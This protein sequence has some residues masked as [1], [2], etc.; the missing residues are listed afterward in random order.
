MFSQTIN[1]FIKEVT[2][3]AEKNSKKVKMSGTEKT[4]TH[5]LTP[6][7]KVQLEIPAVA[8]VITGTGVAKVVIIADENLHPYIDVSV[9][10]GSLVLAK[11]EDVN[12]SKSQV[13]IMI[14]APGQL[15]HTG[16]FGSGEIKFVLENV[17]QVTGRVMGSGC[18]S[19]EGAVKNFIGSVNG[20]GSLNTVKLKADY[21]RIEI[22]GSGTV[23][24]SPVIELD[25][26]ILG[27]GKVSYNGNPKVKANTT[28]S[29]EVV[30]SNQKFN[31]N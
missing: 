29:G 11:T 22:V 9:T 4:E 15:E 8:E 2:A 10:D 23:E 28:G 21:V 14:H 31:H 30:Q 1:T 25:A 17:E 12:F 3:F 24:V 20:S 7:N 19:I 16:V 6:F 26:S 18:I 27:S 5:Q 13:R